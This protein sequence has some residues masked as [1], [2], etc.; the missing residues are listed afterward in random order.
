MGNFYTS[1]TACGADHDSVVKAMKG[2][3]AAVSP[4]MNGYTVVWDA[5]CEKQD[6]RIIDH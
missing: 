4:T 1:F 5:E 6:Q 2:R 3:T